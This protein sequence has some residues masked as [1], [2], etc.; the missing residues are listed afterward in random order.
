MPKVKGL[1]IEGITTKPYRAISDLKKLSLG[2]YPLPLSNEAKIL[3]LRRI[4]EPDFK[5]IIIKKKK[6]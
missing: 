2:W 4:E 1:M 6:I 5:K 3:I